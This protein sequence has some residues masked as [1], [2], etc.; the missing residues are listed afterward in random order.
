MKQTGNLTA[1]SLD[2]MLVVY[3]RR[4]LRL[5]GFCLCVNVTTLLI[6]TFVSGVPPGQFHGRTQ[7]SNLDSFFE[8][9]ASLVRE[10]IRLAD[11]AENQE[12]VVEYCISRLENL[13]SNCVN[14]FDLVKEELYD[15]MIDSVQQH[16]ILLRSRIAH[17]A[18]EESRASSAYN[19]PLQSKTHFER[20]KFACSKLTEI[21][22]P[23]LIF[24]M[25][26]NYPEAVFLGRLKTCIDYS[27]E[28]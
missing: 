1:H 11:T 26:P 5:G 18:V 4:M 21:I 25:R 7:P 16:I 24:V 19:A 28:I 12:G 13:L 10:V 20:I 9:A 3:K 23:Y 15:R 6:S 22:S 17:P 8:R 27:G 2:L 14:L